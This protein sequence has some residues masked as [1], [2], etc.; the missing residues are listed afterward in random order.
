MKTWGRLVL[1]LASV[2]I[3]ALLA[4]GLFRIVMPEIGWA[5]RKEEV[6][7]WSSDEYRQFQ[8]SARLDPREK[9]ILFLGDSFLAGS[10]VSDLDQRFPIR[11][12]TMLDRRVSVQIL[13]AGGWGTDQQLL[14]FKHKGGLWEP[15]LVVV[16]F[17]ANND[18]SN[19]LSHKGS[20][21]DSLKPYFVSEDGASLDLLDGYGMP[22]DSVATNRRGDLGASQDRPPLRSYLLDY[23]RFVFRRLVPPERSDSSD[24]FR[25]VDE[26]YRRFRYRTRK[27]KEIYRRQS[28]LSWSPQYGVNHVSAYVHDEFDLNTYQW[29]LLEL[30]L[31]ALKREVE[32]RGGKLVVMLCRGS[33][34]DG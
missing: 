34:T 13:A 1:F 31:K 9:R 14:A 16:A 32:T 27:T 6:L 23:S 10:G 11:L 17:C 21:P 3:A 20:R 5:Q 19:I 18:L 8:P 29:N 28:N 26:R 25:A 12:E 24:A 22:I 7:G 2:S 30:L 33:P 4:E 15:D